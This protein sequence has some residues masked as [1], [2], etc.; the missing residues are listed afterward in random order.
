MHRSVNGF[1]EAYRRFMEHHI[2][3][4][5][6]ERKRRVENHG[7]AERKFLSDVWWPAFGDLHGL[8]PEY[9]ARDC[10]DGS[11]FLDYAWEPELLRTGIEIDGFGPHGI[12]ASKMRFA[13]D[14]IRQ[15]DLQ[16]D[17]WRVLRFAYDDLSDRPRLCRQ[18][19]QQARGFWAQALIFPH[20]PI[21]SRNGNAL[22]GSE[23]SFPPLRSPHL[24][25][26]ALPREPRK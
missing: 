25:F 10:K 4:S 18:I 3:K 26:G 11:R 6:G 2:R 1:E 23:K 14:R 22:L 7:H 19:V 21:A 5:R 16:L 15:N 8:V 13:D 17:G 20:R 24:R 12:D 9:E